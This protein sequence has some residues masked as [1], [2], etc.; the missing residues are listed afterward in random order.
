MRFHRTTLF[1]DLECLPQMNEIP[2]FLPP[3]I[4]FLR[5]H[6]DHKGIFRK[7][8]NKEVINQLNVAISQ[9]VPYIPQDADVDEVA[10][11]LKMWLR[12]LPTPLI[13]PTIISTYSS[14]DIL[15]STVDIL[16]HIHELN[17]HC[18]AMIFSLIG[19]VLKNTDK[20]LMTFSNLVTS[21]FYCF[22][23]KFENYPDEFQFKN[24]FYKAITLLNADGTD[25]ILSSTSTTMPLMMAR[26]RNSRTCVATLKKRK[27]SREDIASIGIDKIDFINQ[28]P[29]SL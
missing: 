18:V 11:F 13:N 21:F 9:H 2:V 3:I 15:A 28:K 20:N 6:V 12:V 25:F 22:S 26:A 5:K 23:Q 24:F 16:S 1:V 7:V 10:G 14:P 8:G 17:R 19:D 29:E 4:T 27:F